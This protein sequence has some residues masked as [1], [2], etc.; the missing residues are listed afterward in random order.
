VKTKINKTSVDALRA[1]S[2]KDDRLSDSEIVGFTAKRLPSGTVIFIYRYRNEKGVRQQ[3][4]LGVYGKVTPEQAR[5]EAMK[6]QGK[7]AGGADIVEER[8]T[9]RARDGMTVNVLLD[10]FAEGHLKS[11]ASGE[12]IKKFFFDKHVRPAIGDTII[13]DLRRADIVALLD[14]IAAKG[15][16]TTADRT[17]AYVRKAFNWHAIRD[18]KFTP[19][20]VRGMARIKPLERARDRVLDDDEIADLWQALD[21][22]VEENKIHPLH[23]AAAHTLMFT[24]MRLRQ[25]TEM[26][27]AEIKGH[28]WLIPRERNRKTKVAHLCHLTDAAL[29]AIGEGDG[30][31]VFSIGGDKPLALA[32]VVKAKVDRKLA[33]IRKAKKHHA[34]RAW[35]WHD[36]RRTGRSLMSGMSD[37]GVTPDHAERVLGHILPGLRRTYDIY[38][39]KKEKQRAL[40][41]LS[42]HIVSITR[43]RG[44]GNV[45]QLKR[46]RPAA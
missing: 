13:Y 24:T 18:E 5:I 26:R 4:S 15:S 25:V 20:L 43:P 33:E 11:L 45:V 34:M 39:Y 1:G 21:E 6:A 22:L 16:D 42:A 8:K 36:L 44:G 40:E 17:L 10:R 9:I 38:N 14:K 46:R 2:G 29:A 28:D 35:T 12:H 27:R 31:L 30:E 7:V 19:P 37:Q 3:Q 32:S 23:R 41:C